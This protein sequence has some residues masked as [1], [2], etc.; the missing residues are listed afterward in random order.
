MDDKRAYWRVSEDESEQLKQA[1][2]MARGNKTRAALLLNM[3]PRQFS[4][5]LK[6]LGL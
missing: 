2:E 5:R 3:T 4:Y 6:K 1:L